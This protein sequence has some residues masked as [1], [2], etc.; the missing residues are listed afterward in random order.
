MEEY[1]KLLE[2][3]E[4][5]A[6]RGRP[7][8]VDDCLRLARMVGE[9][10]GDYRAGA[11]VALDALADAAGRVQ[12][13]HRG[14]GVETCSIV[15]A[16]SGRCSEDCKWCAQAAAYHTGCGSYLFVPERRWVKAAMA[17]RAAGVERISMVTSGRKVGKADIEKFCSMFEKAPEGIGLC[18]S[19]GLIGIEEMVALKKAG[20]TRYHCNLET[21][22]RLFP[23]LC[24]THTRR[25]KLDTI[26][27]ARAAGLE[28]CSG[29]IIGMG[30]ELRDRLELVQ[31]AR[32]AGASSVPVNLLCPI[33]GTPLADQPLLSEREIV[34]TVALMRMVA[35]CLT[36]RFAGGRRRLSAEATRRILLGGMN[37]AMMGDLLTTE[38]NDADD[39]RRLFAE[40]EQE[41]KTK[42]NKSK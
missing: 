29:G 37:G 28:V 32:E 2:R 36:L 22:A 38:G 34:L 33:A 13:R 11:D 4:G 9:S 42:Q 6:L 20:V 18:A 41:N 14:D 12:R 25:D 39:D 16:R 30:E 8:S 27:A 1:M 35:P 24:S 23:T 15:N 19:M 5:E 3:V 31:E 10:A 17:S 40:I 7:A 21:S 26:S